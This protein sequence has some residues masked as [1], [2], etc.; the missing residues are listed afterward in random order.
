MLSG[1]LPVTTR[2]R[3]RAA[4]LV[5]PPCPDPSQV[6]IR[7][8]FLRC[9]SLITF[10][11]HAAHPSGV[12]SAISFPSRMGCWAP[13]A[14]QEH[15]QVLLRDQTGSQSEEAVR[16]HSDLVAGKRRCEF[17]I[18]PRRERLHIMTQTPGRCATTAIPRARGTRSR[19]VV[20]SSAFG[21][22]RGA[23]WN[24]GQSLR[25]RWRASCRVSV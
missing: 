20:D 2:M 1:V 18:A 15:S 3:Q 24:G 11:V 10:D 23:D 22:R 4:Q 14:L 9:L 25:Y 6:R 19:P 16:Q 8:L 12:R 21:P 7:E 5:L 13:G 17:S